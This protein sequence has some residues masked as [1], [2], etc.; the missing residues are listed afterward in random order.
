MPFDPLRALAALAIVFVA[1]RVLKF[2]N[3]LRVSIL[4]V[5]IIRPLRCRAQ[6]ISFIPGIRCAFDPLDFPG[7]LLP[8]SWWNPGVDAIWVRRFSSTFF[9]TYSRFVFITCLPQCIESTA[10]IPS[11]SFRSWPDTLSCTPRI[12]TLHDRSSVVGSRVPGL[13]PSESVE[14][15]CTFLNTL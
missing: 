11:R 2:W 7:G 15:C 14:A 1:S 9:Y 8:S 12:S 13:N 4:A 10:T 5:T 3:G 6:E